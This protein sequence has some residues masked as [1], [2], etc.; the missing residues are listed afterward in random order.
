M[1]IKVSGKFA[2]PTLLAILVLAGTVL[3][4]YNVDRESLWFDE[5]ATWETSRSDIIFTKNPLNSFSF[6]KEYLNPP[7][8]DPIQQIAAIIANAQAEKVHL[9]LYFILVFFIKSSIGDSELSLRLLSLISGIL[10]IVILY[11][12]SKLFFC[13]K[14]AIISAAFISLLWFP[15]YYS[16]EARMYMLMVLFS[17]LST[18]LVSR[19]Y[20]SAQKGKPV[21][22]WMI[23]Y[24]FSALFNAYL[25]FCRVVEIPHEKSIGI[26]PAFKPD[27]KS[28][29]GWAL[30]SVAREHV[31]ACER[32]P[33]SVVPHACDMDDA[34]F[35]TKPIDAPTGIERDR[36]LRL[37][38][39]FEYCFGIRLGN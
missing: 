9:P 15:V 35:L 32:E 16:R 1:N 33:C 14:T 30:R 10:S 22:R 2:Y 28:L 8:G 34:I 21:Y 31:I 19:F 6:D 5:L 17:I 24:F 37:H 4:F 27:A 20:F 11:R 23:L 26:H 7:P 29:A 3:R 12:L 38:L 39:C 18:Y 36:C 13:R 25:H